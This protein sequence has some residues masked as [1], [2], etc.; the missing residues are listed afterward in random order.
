MLVYDDRC[1]RITR[2]AWLSIPHSHQDLQCLKSDSKPAA[3]TN[4]RAEVAGDCKSGRQGPSDQEQGQARAQRAGAK[5][6]R[7]VVR[8]PM[9]FAAIDSFEFS[10]TRQEV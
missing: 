8:L 10:G 7:D 6:Q 2:C 4:W 1:R 3:V 9:L 5:C